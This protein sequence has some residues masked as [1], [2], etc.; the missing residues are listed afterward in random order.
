MRRDVY[1]PEFSIWAR[2]II[3]TI[4]NAME[5][6]RRFCTKTGKVLVVGLICFSFVLIKSR[7][8]VK[9]KKFRPKQPSDSTITGSDSMN[10]RANG[11]NTN[12]TGI[13]T[14]TSAFGRG[15]PRSSI[16]DRDNRSW[17]EHN[18]N[19]K[20]TSRVNHDGPCMFDIL[21]CEDG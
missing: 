8:Q 12:S 2:L 1:I 3:E 6:K 5:L 17:K 13:T 18:G 4:V 15:S 14:S 20:L 16:K 19:K 7:Y 9:L 10:G 21:E 11:G